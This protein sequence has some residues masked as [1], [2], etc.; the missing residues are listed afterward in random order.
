M[1]R[2][3]SFVL[4]AAL[5]AV[6]P[7]GSAAMIRGGAGNA[8]L[9]DP[10][11][12]AGAAKIVNHPG[13]I[14]WWEGPPFG[15]G[16]WHSECRGDAEALSAVLADL[17][18]LDVEV[19]RVVVHDGVGHSFWL[20][21]NREPEKLE[22]A[23]IDWAFTVWQPDR[24]ERL[25]NL[26]ADLNP[27]DP[28]DASPPSQID[29]YT[30]RIDWADVTVPEGL[31]VDDQRLVAH[32]FTADDGVVLEGTI[33]EVATGRPIAGTIRLQRVEPR[34]TGGYR[35]PDLAET[36]ADDRG[37]W[38]LT[39]APAAWVRVVAEAEGYAPRV[40]GYGQFDDQP[41]WH[42]YDAVLA[43]P[44][45]VTGRVTDEDGAP[46]I[47]VN[48]RLDNVQAK[49]GGRYESPIEPEART[50][51]D[52]RFRVDGVPAGAASVWVTKPGFCH[53]GLGPS[54]ETPAEDVL[55]Q[56]VRAAGVLVTVD[57]DGK[58]RPDGYMVNMEPEGGSVVGSY[59]GSGNI[60]EQNRMA[61]RAVP[62]GRYVLWGR[63][64]PGSDDEQ[65]E[66][67]TVDLE[68][69]RTTEITLRAR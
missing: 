20:A 24:W 17:A 29:I 35:Y 8:P 11:W 67:V 12:P 49:S 28:A 52:G 61:F 48:V 57:F 45:A 39:H 9:D 41:R 19:R 54:I 58:E 32:G 13:R 21:P 69:G 23:R 10:G 30:A 37:H 1:L 31:A 63:P 33:T 44:A 53:V 15:G 47:D 42:S 65:T 51:A 55:L 62:P 18:R 4:V 66:S 2:V 50:D 34:E 7:R 27:T 38:S 26:P 3:A 6:A 16:Q 14:A 36:T 60:D 25:R 64:N 43:R 56:M 59:G 40:V 68:G 22:K 46:L 5:A